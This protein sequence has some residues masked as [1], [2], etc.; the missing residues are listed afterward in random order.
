MKQQ[1]RIVEEQNQQYITAVTDQTVIGYKYFDYREA[2]EIGLEL[3]GEFKGEVML[4][5]DEAG[6]KAIGTQKAE[7]SS[8]EWKVISICTERQ[9]GI[10]PLYLHFSGK[11]HWI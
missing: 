7:I 1:T 10:L 6:E 8:Q 11:G 5:A 3:R 9:S 2:A 4:S